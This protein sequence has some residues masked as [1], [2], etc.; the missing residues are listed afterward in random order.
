MVKIYDDVGGWEKKQSKKIHYLTINIIISWF[1]IH[2]NKIGLQIE[3][4]QENI[5]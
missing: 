5:K 3:R 1:T 2:E 4:Y